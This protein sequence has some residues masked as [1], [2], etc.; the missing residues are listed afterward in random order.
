MRAFSSTISFISGHGAA[1]LASIVLATGCAGNKSKEGEE[2]PA[3]AKQQTE[4]KVPEAAETPDHAA[5]EAAQVEKPSSTEL[6]A[7]GTSAPDFTAQAHDG[8]TVQLS[9]LRG[10]PV[11]LYFYPKDE[12]PGCTIEAQSFRDEMPDFEQHGATVL[13]VSLDS[14]ESHK[15]F[16]ENHKLQFPLLADTEGEIAAK[17]GVST[18]GGYARRVTFVIDPKGA[19][20]KVYPQV[21]V[22]KHADEVLEVVKS[23]AM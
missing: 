11:V 12:T 2:N 10:K 23:L 20:A 3:P 13:G 19:I 1:L 16:A 18:E 5:P 21:D 7:E 6:L 8:T 4:A 17:Y 9:E 15:Q 22:K 14:I